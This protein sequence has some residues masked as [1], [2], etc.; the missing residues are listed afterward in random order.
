MKICQRCI[1]PDSFPNVTLDNGIC[2][3]C[4]NHDCS[5]RLKKTTLGR[6]KLLKILTSKKTDKYDCVVPL[7]GG[8]DSSYILLY[9][10]R[11][12]GLNP[13]AV[14]SD[15][16]FVVDSAKRNI[17]KIC[18]RLSVDLV[19][20]KSKFHRKITKEALYISKYRGKYFYVC[21]P[22][23]NNNRSIAINEAINRKV[24]FI[25][26]GA[27]DF[28]DDVQ[29]FLSD[30][31][32]TFRQQFAGRTATAKVKLKEVIKDILGDMGLG[33][34]YHTL[35]LCIPLE[36]KLKTIFHFLVYLHYR[37]RNNFDVGVPEGWR[38]F[39]PL[40]VVSFERKEVNTIYFFDYIAYDPCQHVEELQREVG[41]E[42]SL[43]KESRMDCKLH[44]L[45]AYQHLKRTGITSDGFTSSVLIRYGLMSR[46]EAIEKEEMRKK[47]LKRECQKLL[48]ELGI[49]EEDIL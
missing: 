30:D 22:C 34:I 40:V 1:I 27:T 13:L 4:R 41:W 16:G 36:N 2:T 21:G 43:G 44:L 23:E 39:F 14:S 49:E 47:D 6:E 25:I 19:V 18:K 32:L 11:E 31:S 15:S 33:Y 17:E 37:V 26:W 46:R 35:K 7:S 24:P 48:A 42:S 38:K 29:T 12:L 5:P 45:E 3:L 20:H 9:M 28:E 10:V 8:K